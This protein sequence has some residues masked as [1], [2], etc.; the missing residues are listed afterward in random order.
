MSQSYECPPYP[1][2]Q[3]R[4]TSSEKADF[5]NQLNQMLPPDR[6]NGMLAVLQNNLL[7]DSNCQREK[8]IVELRERMYQASNVV[9]TAPNDLSQAEKNYYEYK[10]G[11]GEYLDYLLDKN[12][13]EYQKVIDE[14]TRAELESYK[15]S[16]AL[17]Y[18]FSAEKIHAKEMSKLA[19]ILIKEN[20]ELEAELDSMVGVTTTSDRKIDYQTRETDWLRKIRYVLYTVYI[21]VFILYLLLGNFITDKLYEKKEAWVFVIL[22]CLFPTFIVPHL[23]VFSFWLY[24]KISRLL[25]QTIPKNVY[26]KL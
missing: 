17:I 2:T 20:T 8:K 16:I 26:I 23:S 3:A 24:D 11:S 13:R 7:C 4:M 21:L 9:K 6:L 18:G 10:S 14:M 19:D 1:S 25:G 15:Q 5:S 22:Y 12:K